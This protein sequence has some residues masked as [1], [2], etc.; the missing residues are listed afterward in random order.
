[1]LRGVIYSLM[2]SYYHQ[3]TLHSDYKATV[4]RL[5]QH[6]LARGWRK[7]TLKKYIL[8]SNSKLQTVPPA[9][10]QDGNTLTGDSTNKPSTRDR[11][12]Y[13]LPYHPNDI[14]S[15]RIQQLYQQH[16]HEAFTT[17]GINSLTVAYSRHKNLR[18]QLT[19]A[20]LHQA[21]GREAGKFYEPHGQH[22]PHGAS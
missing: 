8:D 21:P 11:L 16:C 9:G 10:H 7:D 1:M 5:Y 12:F 4:I 22:Q 6:L 20:R 13:H 2:K 14:P 19:Q 18:E 3:K 15:R 17:I